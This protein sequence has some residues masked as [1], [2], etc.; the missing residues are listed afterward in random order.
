MVLVKN[1]KKGIKLNR[2]IH[3][4]P[5]FIVIAYILDAKKKPNFGIKKTVLFDSILNRTILIIILLKM[6]KKKKKRLFL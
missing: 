1:T 2:N 5:P 4:N 6:F 3:K